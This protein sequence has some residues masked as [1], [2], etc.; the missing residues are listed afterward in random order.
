MLMGIPSPTRSKECQTPIQMDW[1]TTWILTLMPMVSTMPWRQA[2]IHRFLSTQTVTVRP[3]CWIQT[4]MMMVSVIRTR[5]RSTVTVTVLLTI[6]M[7]TRTTMGLTTVSRVVVTPTGME[8]PTI[9]IQ[10]LT[11]MGMRTI[12]KGQSIPIMME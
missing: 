9:W 3:M 4:L 8:R 2:P 5:G 6:S 12:L 11:T 7:W 10:I 1:Q